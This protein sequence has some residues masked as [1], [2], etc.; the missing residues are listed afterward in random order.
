M[1]PGLHPVLTWWVPDTG[2]KSLPWKFSLPLPPHLL[3]FTGVKIRSELP[4]RAV[5]S[6]RKGGGSGPSGFHCWPLIFPTITSGGFTLSPYVCILPFLA[7]FDHQSK[8]AQLKMATGSKCHL[9][10]TW[11]CPSS[12]P[13][14]LRWH[15]GSRSPAPSRKS[16]NDAPAPYPIGSAHLALRL[17]LWV[18]AWVWVWDLQELEN[19]CASTCVHVRVS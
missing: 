5:L 14:C 12:L 8:M 7:L 11:W 19:V 17:C 9:S 3:G 10:A 2:S 16:T 6:W 4:V 13:S 1:E 18:W 15:A